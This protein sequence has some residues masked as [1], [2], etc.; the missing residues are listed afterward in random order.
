LIKVVNSGDYSA[1]CAGKQAQGKSPIREEYEPSTAIKILHHAANNSS[2]KEG[3]QSP[4][5]EDPD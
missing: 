2:G 3:S 4:S 5:I 1:V